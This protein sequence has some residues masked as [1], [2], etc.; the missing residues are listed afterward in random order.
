MSERLD[1]VG[2][3]AGV[4]YPV[5]VFLGLGL[6]G[7][8]DITSTDAQIAQFL[9]DLDVV[10]FVGGS[11]AVVA[12]MVCLVVF[13]ARLRAQL[14]ATEASWLPDVV[15]AAATLAAAGHVLGTAA[16][17][18]AILRPEG[19][20]LQL[21]TSIVRLGPFLHWAAEVAM[22]VVLVAAGVEVLR[23][24]GVLPAWLG[25]SGC[26]IGLALF[27][28]VPIAATG[29]PHIP[30]TLGSVWILAVGVSMIRAPVPAAKTA[31]PDSRP[32]SVRQSAPR[33]GK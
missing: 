15:L 8:A 12:A 25:W 11:Y 4:L 7:G 23:R 10:Q 24:R 20:E 17:G 26:V 14:R 6:A 29:I 27:G 28:T 31:T 2:S 5:L 33:T 9:R 13:A 22:A 1:R 21:A 18:P 32:P 19:S 3:A 16:P 30:A